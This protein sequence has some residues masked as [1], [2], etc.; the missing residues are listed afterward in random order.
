MNRDDQGTSS[1]G[2]D[3]PREWRS[4]P[5]AFGLNKRSVQ[6]LLWVAFCVAAGLVFLQPARIPSPTASSR[7]VEVL[8]FVLL[9]VGVA[10]RVIAR[11]WKYEQPRRTLV[12]TGPY[13]C[14]RHP[15][16]LGSFLA[17][18]GLLAIAGSMPFAAVCIL[19]FWLG[20]LPVI[21]GEE[22]FLSRRWGA[23]YEAYRRS[24]SAFVPRWPS[25]RSA[26]EILPR[27]LWGA[28]VREVDAVCLWPA[29]GML[30]LLWRESDY[31]ML[32]PNLALSRGVPVA[33]GVILL[34]G[35]GF[36]RVRR[37]SVRDLA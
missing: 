16:Y 9:A 20:H 31:R 26:A 27:D 30:I 13:A 1:E 37:E 4:R 7:L 17:I 11:G 5:A 28:V 18:S 24:T 3:H 15:L 22:A 35:W 12:T 10:V 25:T 2:L 6:N 33:L 29:V 34:F 8:G 32:Q 36:L 21:A 19:C 14:L 23:A